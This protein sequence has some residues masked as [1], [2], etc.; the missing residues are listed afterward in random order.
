MATRE[1]WEWDATG[2]HYQVALPILEMVAV[3]HRHDVAVLGVIGNDDHLMDDFPEDHTPF[4]YTYWP[5]LAKGWV[6]ACDLANV[7]N[8]GDLILRDARAGRLPWLKYINF[9]GRSYSHEDGFQYGAPNGDEHV[10]LSC[11]SDWLTRSIGGYDPFAP[12][13]DD[14][15]NED[16]D[17]RLRNIDHY[18]TA[19]T[20]GGLTVEG[21]EGDDGKPFVPALPNK[22]GQDLAAL[23]ARPAQL[24][25]ILSAGDKAEIATQVAALIAPQV[26]KAVGDMVAARMKE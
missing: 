24:P 15:M 10:H 26:A 3:A 17:R 1:Y 25:V 22:V 16:Q 12:L 4:S 19:L 7:R 21:V 13:E 9:G 2:R 8:L 11:R 23:R 18:L 6:C 5:V 20:Q 14:D